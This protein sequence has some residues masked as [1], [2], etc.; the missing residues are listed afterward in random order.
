MVCLGK[1]QKVKKKEKMTGYVR[2]LFLFE[3]II[4]TDIELLILIRD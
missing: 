2:L 3:F 4:F 1:E